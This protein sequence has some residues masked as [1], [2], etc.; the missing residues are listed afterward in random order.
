MEDDMRQ[1]KVTFVIET[2]LFQGEN[3]LKGAFREQLKEIGGPVPPASAVRFGRLS[4]KEI[5]DKR[6][7]KGMNNGQ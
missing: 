3:D 2:S 6:H 5:K 1:Y 7:K 4:I